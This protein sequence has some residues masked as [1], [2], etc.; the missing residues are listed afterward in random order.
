[1]LNQTKIHLEERTYDIITGQTHPILGPIPNVGVIPLPLT[2]TG[3][4]STDNADS[5]AGVLVRGTDTLFTTELFV[6]DFIYNN[7]R[8]RKIKYIHSDIMLTLEF[9]FPASL[10]AQIVAVP[11]RNTYRMITA[12]SIDISSTGNPKLQESEFPHGSAT[13]NGGSPLTYD[14]SVY[15]KI[16]FQVSQ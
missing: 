14:V 10:T 6:G 9:A 3:T 16:H 2:K 13:V 7:G 8:I 5:T 15:G 1:M 11:P 12:R 4:F